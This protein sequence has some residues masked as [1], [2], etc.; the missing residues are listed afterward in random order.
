LVKNNGKA[1]DI[2]FQVMPPAAA[3]P[4]AYAIFSLMETAEFFI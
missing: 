1:M 2:I 3:S 4:R